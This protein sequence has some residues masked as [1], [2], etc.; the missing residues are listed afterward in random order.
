MKRTYAVA[1][2]VVTTALA[3]SGP[4]S[5]QQT[6]KLDITFI[7][8]EGGAATLLVS[9][10]GE[11]LLIDTGYEVGDRDAKRIAAA[12]QHAGL[13]QIDYVVISHWHADH[14]GGLAALAKMIP[15]GRFFDHGEGASSRRTRHASTATR[16][17]RAPSAPSSSPATRS[18]IKGFDALVV[19]SDLKLLP[20]AVNGGGPNPLC[21]NAARMAA[22]AP[23]NVARSGC[24]SPT[25]SSPSRSRRP[26]LVYGHATRLPDRQGRRGHALPDEPP[27][28]LDDAGRRRS[29]APS[30]RR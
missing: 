18:P 1:A 2:A 5:A 3:V 29:S 21:A 14:V 15:I 27:S 23:E 8:T 12:V 30:S 19:S 26:R 22:A 13:K 24:S 10:S 9:P 20:E 6:G 16:R 25:T 4:A 17:W 11:L 28:R 7:D